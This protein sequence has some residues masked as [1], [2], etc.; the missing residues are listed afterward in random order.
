LL[1][2]QLLSP[3]S[4]QHRTINPQ[5]LHRLGLN[6]HIMSVKYSKYFK[7]ALARLATIVVVGNSCQDTNSSPQHHSNTEPS[8]PTRRRCGLF[9]TS[10]RLDNIFETISE[11]I[12]KSWNSLSSTMSL[13]R[14]RL[15]PSAH[16][17]NPDITIVPQA[18]VE[19]LTPGTTL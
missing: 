13:A 8:L 19:Y 12:W 7:Q 16:A 14:H 6:S 11:R 2:H 17:P 3:A 1:G 4:W 18:G 10:S 9:D 5:P 15:L